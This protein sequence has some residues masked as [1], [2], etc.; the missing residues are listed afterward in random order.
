MYE[1]LINNALSEDDTY[2]NARDTVRA[3]ESICEVFGKE[4]VTVMCDGVQITAA[5]LAEAADIQ[6]CIDSQTALPSTY[7]H[8]FVGRNSDLARGSDGFPH[9]VKKPP[10]PEDNWD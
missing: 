9:G 5:Q 10:N 1:I 6:T 2:D 4:V 8:G 3:Y 7:Q